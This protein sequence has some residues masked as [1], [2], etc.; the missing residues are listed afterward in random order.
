MQLG[1]ALM[2]HFLE[3][4]DQEN[5]FKSDLKS[6]QNQFWKYDLKSNQNHFQEKWLKSKSKSLK[7]WL[8]SISIKFNH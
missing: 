4:S 3:G 2:G 1:G 7:N 5:Q 6:N 8:Q